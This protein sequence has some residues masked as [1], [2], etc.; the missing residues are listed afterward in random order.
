MTGGIGEIHGYR[1]YFYGI[2]EDLNTIDSNYIRSLNN[3]GEYST[4][5]EINFK[6]SEVSNPKRFILALPVKRNRE[7]L[8][9]AE[10][11]STMNMDI[12]SEYKH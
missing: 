11:V 9:S 5:L 2:T 6:A 1:A 4:E 3:G 10:L 8:I 7:G 12:L